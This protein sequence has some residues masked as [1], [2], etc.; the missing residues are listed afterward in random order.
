MPDQHPPGRTIADSANRELPPPPADAAPVVFPPPAGP[1]VPRQI[2]GPDA[3]PEPVRPDPPA[4]PAREPG[5]ESAAD[6]GTRRTAVGLPRVGAVAAVAAAV[7]RAVHGVLGLAV[8]ALVVGHAGVLPAPASHAVVT[9]AI[10]ATLTA[11]AYCLT[12]ALVNLLR[13]DGVRALPAYYLR[14]CKTALPWTAFVLLVTA[15][16]AYGLSPAD[17]AREIRRMLLAGLVQAANWAALA[18]APHEAAASGP[19]A[20]GPVSGLWLLGVLGQFFLL[21]PPL[22]AALF[23]A[24]RRRPLPAAL[25]TLAG[26]AGA[27]AAAARLWRAADADWWV[28]GTQ[29]RVPDLLAG[30]A[31]ALFAAW[32]ADRASDKPGRAGGAVATGAGL[33]GLAA[34]GGLGWYVHRHPDGW[35]S[36]AHHISTTPAAAAATAVAALGLTRASVPV[37]RLFA[38]APLDE[39]GRMAYPVLLVHPPLFWLLRRG[40]PAMS[41]AALLVVAGVLTWLIALILYYTGLRA[42]RRKWRGARQSIAVAL[43]VAAAAGCA[44]RLP[45][46]LETELRPGGRPLVVGLGDGLAGDLAAGLH[47]NGTKFAGVSGVAADRADCGLFDP[48]RVRDRSAT[49]H[50]KPAACAG[51]AESWTLEL[52]ATRP[53]AVVLHLG[54][55]AAQSVLDGTWKTACDPVYRERYLALLDRALTL[56]EREAPGAAVVVLN[57]RLDNN[58]AD[59]IDTACFNQRI[60]EFADTHQG[61]VRLADFDAYVCPNGACRTGLPGGKP[62]YTGLDVARLTPQA[63]RFVVPWIEEQ[64]SA[65]RAARTNPPGGPR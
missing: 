62:F 49:E 14:R 60:K 43:V 63:Q 20:A 8:T 18:G 54:R 24:C 19:D 33:L 11:A 53:E 36:A 61:R 37:A 35:L 59:P 52:R 38:A 47:E 32:A 1:L 12:A 26:F 23:L 5:A 13:R 34:L 41:D 50:T 21:W 6:A 10:D 31:A 29:A 45:A 27:A 40:W 46:A 9:V 17:E 39:L 4:A 56:I 48:T 25:L 16:C 15:A 3:V 64:V 55:D 58:S 44:Y 57:E 2:S 7:P 51:W 30:A 22:F 65:A 28:L 42:G